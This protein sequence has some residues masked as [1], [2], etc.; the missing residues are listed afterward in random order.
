MSP[1]SARRTRRWANRSSPSS[2]PADWNDAGDA[3]AAEI[4]AY[5]RANLS[6]VKIPRRIDFMKELPRHATG[7]LYK[8]LIRD[9]YWGKGD[10]T[11]V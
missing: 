3:L 5:A 10:G 11:I 1:W 9:A 7:K 8:R 6:G 2:S 4:A